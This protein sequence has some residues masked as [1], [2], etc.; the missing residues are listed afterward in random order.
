MSAPRRQVALDSLLDTKETNPK[1]L[2]RAT[3][4]GTSIWT[5]R[6]R[7]WRMVAKASGESRE[8]DCKSWRCSIHGPMNAWRWKKRLEMVPWQLMLTIT[9]VPNDRDVAAKAWTE[10]VRWLKEQGVRTYCRVLERGKLHGMRHYHILLHGAAYVDIGDI[11]AKCGEVGFGKH[12]WVTRVGHAAGALRYILK[13]LFKDLGL[14]DS[15]EDRGWRR[16][17]VSRNILAW[18]RIAEARR[19]ALGVDAPDG[20]YLLWKGGTE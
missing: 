15:R 11:S 3:R 1:G 14:E 7:S 5:C 4:D 6:Y 9:L 8:F 13:Y 20:E 17:C 18:P 12:C 10:L 19:V 16:I 2:G